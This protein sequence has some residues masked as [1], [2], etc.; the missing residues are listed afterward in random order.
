ML[1]H[2]NISF[3]FLM[4]VDRMCLLHRQVTLHSSTLLYCRQRFLIVQCNASRCVE[5]PVSSQTALVLRNF[6]FEGRCIPAL[7]L[8]CS[9]FVTLSQACGKLLHVDV[10]KYKQKNSA[11]AGLPWT[12]LV[13]AIWSEVCMQCVYMYSST[14][15]VFKL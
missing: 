9:S 15:N 10:C 11:F 7:P 8:T 12:L 5:S 6:L 1:L 14:K 13:V 4:Y 3:V 2:S